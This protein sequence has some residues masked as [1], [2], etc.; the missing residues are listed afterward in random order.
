MQHLKSPA[1]LEESEI[2]DEAEQQILS[3]RIAQKIKFILEIIDMCHDATGDEESEAFM[4]MIK[5][6]MTCCQEL[7]LTLAELKLQL[8]DQDGVT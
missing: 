1:V 6:V 2:E 3:G 4:Q 7:L 5:K 8:S